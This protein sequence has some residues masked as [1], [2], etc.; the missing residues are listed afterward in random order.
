MPLALDFTSTLERGWI[1]PV[2][3]TT[4]ARSPRSAAASLEGSISWFGRRAAY[5]PYPPPTRISATMLPM[6]MRR[7]RFLAVFPLVKPLPLLDITDP[8]NRIHSGC[9]TLIR[10]STQNVPALEVIDERTWGTV[11]RQAAGRLKFRA[12]QPQR[13]GDDGNR[14]EAHRRTGNHGTK[15]PVEDWIENPR[16]DGD[17]QQIVDERK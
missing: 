13:I 6:I 3:T 9:C 2:A 12:P 10:S 7:R 16:R 5:T 15:Q 8:Q 14:T 1:L 17:S 4:F 11:R